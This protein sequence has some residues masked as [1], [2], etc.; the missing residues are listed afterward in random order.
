PPPPGG[1]GG[2]LCLNTPGVVGPPGGGHPG[3]RGGAGQRPA[4]P[5][6]GPYPRSPNRACSAAIAAR[7]AVSVRRMRGPSCRPWNPAAAN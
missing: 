1:G 3:K 7:P 4:L 5:G 2:G 6:I